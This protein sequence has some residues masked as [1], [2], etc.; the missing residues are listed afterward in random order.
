MADLQIEISTLAGDRA[1]DKTF[2]S[3]FAVRESHQC[4]LL[5]NR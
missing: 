5:A 4:P 3:Q 2:A 1:I